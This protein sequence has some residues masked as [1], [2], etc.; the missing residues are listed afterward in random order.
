MQHPGQTVGPHPH[1]GDGVQAQQGKVGE[2]VLGEGLA[3]EVGVDEA[4]ATQAHLAGTGAADVRQLELVGV[5]HDHVLHLALAGEQDA[6]L[7]VGG[8]GELG[9][10]TGELRADQLPGQHPAAVGVSQSLE[11]ARLES[12]GVAVDV[13]QVSVGPSRGVRQVALCL[14]AATGG[15]H[16][17]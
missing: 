16:P 12:E 10:V 3:L 15:A 9:E 6:H 17:A 11:V 5:A 8:V 13:L 7:A 4:Q 14:H 1:R 2:V